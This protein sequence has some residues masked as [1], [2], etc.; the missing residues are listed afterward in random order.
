MRWQEKMRLAV[1]HMPDGQALF[2][3][4]CRRTAV[5]PLFAP[6]PSLRSRPLTAEISP[7]FCCIP[8]DFRPLAVIAPELLM[9]KE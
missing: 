6:R 5:F 9:V 7:S 2:A 3:L 4:L 8:F 1:M